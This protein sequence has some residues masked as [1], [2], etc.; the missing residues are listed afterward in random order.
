MCTNYKPWQEL[1]VHLT[2]NHVYV[3]KKETQW[4]EG[5]NGLTYTIFRRA[6]LLPGQ[7]GLR[8]QTALRLVIVTP[9][10]SLLLGVQGACVWATHSV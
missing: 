3:G 4:R 1:M 7:P 6:G 5:R 9:R 8:K 2:W 10:V